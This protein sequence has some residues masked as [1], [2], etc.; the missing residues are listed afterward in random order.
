[1]LPSC[2]MNKIKVPPQSLVNRIPYFVYPWVVLNFSFILCDYSGGSE[3]PTA[4]SALHSGPQTW[5]VLYF[6]EQAMLRCSTWGKRPCLQPEMRVQR[7]GL[8][9]LP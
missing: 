3:L 5:Q 7:A 9:P 8:N 1:M 4:L 2:K 6:A